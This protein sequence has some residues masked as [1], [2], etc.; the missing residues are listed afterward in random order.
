MVAKRDYYEILGV[1]RDTSDEELKKVYRKLAIKYHPDKNQGKKESEEKFKEI[2]EA[3]EVLSDPQ[4]R[5]S[6][7]IFGHT[8]GHEGFGGFGGHEAGGVGDIFNDIFE[9]FFGNTSRGRRPGRGADLRYN[10]EISFEDAAFGLETKIKIPKWVNCSSCNGTGAKSAS[11]FKACTTCKGSGQIRFQQGFFSVSR[12]CNHC[13]GEG[14][15]ITEKCAECE[16]D[17]KIH[18]ERTL[19]LKIPPGVETGTK[20]RLTGEGE[21]GD[22][23]GPPG[24]LYVFL[25]VK[26]HPIFTRENGDIL[27]D[28]Q[29]SFVQAA[30]GGKIEIPTLKSTTSLKIPPGTQHGKTFRL[31]GMGIVD[32]RNSSRIGDQVVRINIKIPTKLT[33]RQQELLEEFAKTSEEKTDEESGI[34]EKVKNLFE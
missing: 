22:N 15:I 10:L 5:K 27:Y 34:F 24:D 14:K 18:T 12:T 1:N 23:G 21:P 2:S 28:T 16:G 19:S 8:Q 6:Y 7:D 17:K 20:L 13:H 29:I 30:L 3:Y 31:K 25:T 4:K 33:Q 26:E 9:D 11:S 32:L